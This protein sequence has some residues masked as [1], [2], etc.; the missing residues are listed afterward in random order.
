VSH[1][2]DA[3]SCRETFAR[4]SEYLDRELDPGVCQRLET[5]LDGCPP[6]RAF[7]DS[8][9]RTVSL[10]GGLDRPRLDATTRRRVVD[11]FE[12]LREELAG[13]GSGE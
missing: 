2:H 11:A 8:L 10:V 6:C 13:E 7:L 1:P 5:H 4:L 3:E 12:R 9:R